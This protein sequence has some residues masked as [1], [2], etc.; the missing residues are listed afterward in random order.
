GRSRVYTITVNNPQART[1]ASVYTPP[2]AQP[3]TADTQASG[4]DDQLQSVGYA[5]NGKYHPQA[6]DSWLIPDGG[7]F[8]YQAKKGQR[9]AIRETRVAGM[10]WRYLVTVSAPDGLTATHAYTVVYITPATHTALLTGIRINGTNIPGFNPRIHAYQASV[11]DPDDWTILPL[12]D[13]TD[14]MSVVV[15]KTGARAAITV[16]S[17]DR[18]VKTIYTVNVNQSAGLAETGASQAGAA[19]LGTSLAALGIIIEQL[20]RKRL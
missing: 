6:S 19:T 16:T 14:G 7:V 1:A 5:L 2:A 4:S 17:A 13:K 18:L 8:S 9:V 15:D 10:T 11:P 3:Q 12:F 20:K